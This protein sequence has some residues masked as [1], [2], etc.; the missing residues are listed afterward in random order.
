MS[1]T[2]KIALA[3]IVVV[4]IGIAAYYYWPMS[5]SVYYAPGQS[6]AESGSLAPGTS[7]AA[8]S[9]NA[10]SIDSQMGGLN[11][12]SASMNQSFS[13]APVSQSY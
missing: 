10:A 2:A 5:N 11:S 6:N 8:L 4:L 7:D 13:D 1:S 12:D 9:Q 3:V